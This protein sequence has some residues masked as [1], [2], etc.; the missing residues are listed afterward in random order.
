MSNRFQ[1]G[2]ILGQMALV[3]A[4]G[5]IVLLA[6]TPVRAEPGGDWGVTLDSAATLRDSRQLDDQEWSQRLRGAIWG[7]YFLPLDNGGRVVLSAEGS[8]LYS[9]E[10]DY[11]FDVDRLRVSSLHPG[12]LGADGVL[13][14]DA[15]RFSF[16]DPTGLVLN[17]TADGVRTS[18]RFPT[19]TVEISGA[20][21]G[22]LL[23]PSSRIR[24]T[25]ADRGDEED[26]DE[27]F[28][29]ARVLAQLTAR[30]PDLPGRQSV[31]AGA[32]AQWDLRDDD[33]DMTLNSQYLSLLAT[34]PVVANLYHTNFVTLSTMQTSL[35]SDSDTGTALLF[36]SS[37]R[38]L[39]ADWLGSR[40]GAGFTYASG[41]DSGIDPFVPIN[42]APTGT[43][44]RPR[45]TNLMTARF[46]YAI[47]PWI[48]SQSQTAKNIELSTGLR[49]FFRV[50]DG[51]PLEGGSLLAGL[52]LEDDD[53]YAGTE[54]EW[55]VRARLLPDLGAAL[56]TGLFLPGS[57]AADAEPEFLGRFELS[58]SL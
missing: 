12:A 7:E 3:A 37:L 46:T 40:F 50:Q 56:T 15:G 8:Y 34:G 39:R 28:G 26:D 4:V 19:V 52:S 43:V 29:P 21:T 18:L 10:R 32:L 11:L 45:L 5:G 44:F 35:G 25:D 1:S 42:E 55:A 31:S 17:H 57:G 51:Q 48:T 33:A 6:V 36:G 2:R 30:L 16:R 22:L 38:Y 20:Y 58:L 53:R 27:F 13:A 9:D 23:N 47:R 49:S 14:L 24:M 41:A 54:L